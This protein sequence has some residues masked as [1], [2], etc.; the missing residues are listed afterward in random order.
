[1]IRAPLPAPIGHN[2]G[3]ARP[4]LLSE[5]DVKARLAAHPAWTFDGARLSREI[6]FADFSEA[7]GFMARAALAAE[8]LDHHPD[9]TNV[10][11]RVSVSLRTHDAGGVT[12]LDFRLAAEMDR[13]A[14]G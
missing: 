10:W 6:R 2:R 14:G 12:E 13:I 9:W 3:M 1:M 4:P 11:N 8:K 5:S 7:F